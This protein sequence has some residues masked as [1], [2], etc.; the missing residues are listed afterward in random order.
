MLLIFVAKYGYFYIFVFWVC[1]WCCCFG[2]NLI[3]WFWCWI[4]CNNGCIEQNIIIPHIYQPIPWSTN[5][6]KTDYN[7]LSNESLYKRGMCTISLWFTETTSFSG[8]CLCGSASFQSIVYC[9]VQ[10][11]KWGIQM[12]FFFGS[13]ARGTTSIFHEGLSCCSG[14]FSWCLQPRLAEWDRFPMFT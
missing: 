11:G 13:Y 6:C 7:E 1:C 14:L 3:L 9:T 8:L 4:V 2:A 10:L 5:I 12:R